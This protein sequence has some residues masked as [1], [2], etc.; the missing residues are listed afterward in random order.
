MKGIK[1]FNHKM[2]TSESNKI[3]LSVYDDKRYIKDDGIYTLSYGHK[4]IRTR[5]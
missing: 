2:H 1:S 4:D 5:N 3:S